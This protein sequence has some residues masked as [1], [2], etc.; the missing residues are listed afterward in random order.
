MVVASG[1]A[2]KH[3]HE[4]DTTGGRRP[5]SPARDPCASAAGVIALARWA[6]GLSPAKAGLTQPREQGSPGHRARGLTR[7][8]S[9]QTH[10][11]DLSRSASKPMIR[12]PPPALNESAQI[13]RRFI[14]DYHGQLEE[15]S[16]AGNKPAS[17]RTSPG[18]AH[19]ASA[20]PGAHGT[21][22]RRHHCSGCIRSAACETP[23][24][25]MARYIRNV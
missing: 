2:T 25:D 15:S 3:R 1:A 23:G 13:I 6:A 24:P 9:A 12:V 7:T 17:S 20:R 8:R 19:P 22:Y 4:T 21:G 11:V 10:P 5:S 18:L 16:Q 14:E